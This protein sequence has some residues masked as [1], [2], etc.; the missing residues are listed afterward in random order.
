MQQLAMSGEHDAVVH[1][2]RQPA[3][4]RRAQPYVDRPELDWAGLLAEADTMS[5]RA[6]CI[7]LQWGPN[8]MSQATWAMRLQ[9]AE[10]RHALLVQ[11]GRLTAAR[12]DTRTLKVTSALAKP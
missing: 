5:A 9:L 7:D 11:E 6:W 3:V 1:I 10:G 2:L 12:I 4:W 8:G